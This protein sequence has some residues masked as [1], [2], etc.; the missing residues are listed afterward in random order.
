MT[1]QHEG[2][3]PM[4]PRSSLGMSGCVRRHLDHLPDDYGP[5]PPLL[6][7]AMPPRTWSRACPSPAR[8]RWA[9]EHPAMPI[10]AATLKSGP[11][12]HDLADE[13]QALDGDEQHDY[14]AVALPPPPTR[15]AGPDD[16]GSEV[17]GVFCHV[18]VGRG[19]RRR[20]C[21][22]ARRCGRE[23]RVMS[24]RDPP[25]AVP[26][27]FRS[28]RPHRAR[29]SAQGALPPRPRAHP[30]TGKFDVL[31]HCSP[32]SIAAQT[33]RTIAHFARLLEPLFTEFS[34]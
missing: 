32:P 8:R 19:P 34:A 30:D 20:V 16:R 15:W 29:R 18:M 24:G 22:C 21:P 17:D 31:A 33:L 28:Y 6:R 1:N 7:P 26:R 25:S 27:L 9:D 12:N 14:A 11:S 4:G 3:A 10:S 2:G 5:V 23:T 13:L